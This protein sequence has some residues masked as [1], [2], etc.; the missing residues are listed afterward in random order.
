MSSRPEPV[1]PF[2]H[3]QFLPPPLQHLCRGFL[4]PHENQRLN[5]VTRRTNRDHHPHRDGHQITDHHHPHCG[6]TV[7]DEEH[8]FLKSEENQRYDEW[9]APYVDPK[10]NVAIEMLFRRPQSI[11]KRNFLFNLCV[12]RIPSWRSVQTIVLTSVPCPSLPPAFVLLTNLQDLKITRC[13]LESLPNDFGALR[14]KLTS[15]HL[16]Y[17]RLSTFDP[18]ICMLTRLT[19]LNLIDNAID[20][21]LPREFERLVH[22]TDLDLSFNSIHSVPP[23]LCGLTNLTS[24]NLDNNDIYEALPDALGDLTGLTNLDLGFNSCD[25]LPDSICA[26]RNLRRLILNGNNLTSLPS[27][28]DKIRSLEHLELSMNRFDHL[29]STLTLLPRLR[30]LFMDNNR[31]FYL[32]D[33][34]GN[35]T[36]LTNLWLNNERISVLPSSFASLTNLRQ[37]VLNWSCLQIP[38]QPTALAGID[39]IRDWFKVH[40][41]Q[42]K[43]LNFSFSNVRNHQ[44]ILLAFDR[45]FSSA[46]LTPLCYEI[47]DSKERGFNGT[48]GRRNLA[49]AAVNDFLTRTRLQH[50]N[51][52]FEFR[53]SPNIH[54]IEDFHRD[55]RSDDTRARRMIINVS[56]NSVE[57]TW[58]DTDPSHLEE[59]ISH[60]DLRNPLRIPF[61]N[62]GSGTY[63]SRS[64]LHAIPPIPLQARA[65]VIVSWSWAQCVSHSDEINAVTAAL[66]SSNTIQLL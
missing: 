45:F 53:Y 26:L 25:T 31:L 40:R 32:P 36:S 59:R 18:E 9:I 38:P 51:L 10:P 58:F 14:A 46:I 7:V 24:L 60:S 48:K 52:S 1:G 11:L 61:R 43:L 56:T 62:Q 50:T 41:H 35:L 22:L 64:T 66:F 30:T 2:C 16:G 55:A 37:L 47:R 33:T 44:H 42:P 17:N 39:A 49:I 28:F 3:G 19:K 63:M 34:I 12:E 8:S 23:S 27:Q 6:Q 21:P 5:L 15:V 54:M 20:G 65:L 4:N 13:N 57:H 29:P